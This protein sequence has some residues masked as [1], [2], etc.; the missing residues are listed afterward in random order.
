MDLENVPRGRTRHKRP[1]TVC[2]HAHES[3]EQANPEGEKVRQW[4]PGAGGWK[5]TAKEN[6]VS[7]GGLEMFWG[8]GEV[9]VAQSCECTSTTELYTLNG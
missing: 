9:M 3:P 7:P 6:V 2:F 5:G 4:L 8:Q 1:H